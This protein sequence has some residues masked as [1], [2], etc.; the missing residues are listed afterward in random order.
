MAHFPYR[1]LTFDCFG[2][3]MDW[4]RGQEEAMASLPELVGHEDAFASLE[5]ARMEAEKV[6]QGG[7]FLPYREI[8][9]LSL[10]EAA[11]A[12]LGIPLSR[13]SALAFADTQAA[14]PAYPDSKQALQRIAAKAIIGLLSNCDAAPLRHAAAQGLGLSAPLL[15]PAEAVRSYKPD[16]GHWQAALRTLDCTAQEV[17]HVSAYTYYDLA[18]AHRLGFP[19]AFL[20]RDGEEA[21]GHFPLAY[22]ARDLADLA[23]QL[24]C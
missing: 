23:D 24:G 9:A 4:R 14:W 12:A 3:L 11:D 16:A 19:V 17:L 22:Q 5:S 2:T 10:L 1:A 7:P 13:A 15:I 21:P 18:P 20:A 6:L 8:L